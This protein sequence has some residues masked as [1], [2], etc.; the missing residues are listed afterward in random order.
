[1]KRIFVLFLI[2]S[3]TLFSFGNTIK[4]F[5]VLHTND[6]HSS[7]V[8]TPPLDNHSTLENPTLGGFSRLSSLVNSV[9]KTNE[10]VLLLSGGDYIGGPAFAWLTLYGYSSEIS[11]MQKIGY[12]AVTI[13]NHEYDYGPDILAKY[14]K[15]AGYPHAH[16][17]TAVIAS[18]TVIPE[19]HPLN[20]VE[21]KNTHIKVLDNGLKIGIFGL[22]GKDA[23]RV[24][25]YAEPITF[26]NRVETA[27]KSVEAL[28]KENVDIIILLGHTGYAEDEELVKEVDGIDLIIS[29]HSHTKRFEPLIVNDTI[30][31]Q[32][33]SYLQY[34]GYL[35]LAY[36]TETK[37]LSI[38]NGE[39]PFLIPLDYTIAPDPVIEKEIAYYTERL[40][41]IVSDLTM[42]RF[43]SIYDIVAYSDFEVTN[44]P[45]LQES[46][47]GNFV[48]DAMRFGVENATGKKVDL[49]V[50]ANG[51]IRGAMTPGQMDFSKGKI[52][53]YDIVELVGLGFGPEYSPGYPLISVYL[54]GEEIRK[55]M[56]IS[57]LL[58]EFY[59]NTYFLQY[60]GASLEY[61]ADRTFLFKIPFTNTR[62]P[63]TKSVTDAKLFTGTGIQNDEDMINLK[64]ND[65]KLYHVV[66]DYYLAAFLPF[67]GEVL[68]SLGLV[69]KNEHGEEVEDIEDLIIYN[70]NMEYKVWQAVLEYAA[71]QQ[72]IDGKNY[73]LDYYNTTAD[74]IVQKKALPVLF[75]PVVGI[76]AAAAAGLFFLLSK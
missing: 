63:S 74:R 35:D 26:A 19:G 21:I 22:M 70:N 24:A 75:W 60:S 40:N 51:V 8:P 73:I 57:I 1:M 58:C 16:N 42:N 50:Q 64:K 65:Q 68:P 55:V 61:S 46:P 6:E 41:G 37:K 54:T 44:Q 76:G 38:M 69:L 7:L 17:K 48:A 56:E 15:T 34:V 49:A 23:E 2:L 18:N 39:K 71:D 52:S 67:V 62:V 13:G 47:F 66:T 14:Y 3:I 11:L 27:K 43:N 25:P 32:A 53:F 4:Y 72:E 36:D 5:T 12:D 45:R 20:D 28:R 30:I 10:N 31:V 33:G 9:R 59:G 29:G